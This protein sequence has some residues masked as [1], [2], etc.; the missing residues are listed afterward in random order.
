MSNINFSLRLTH[1]IFRRNFSS[2]QYRYKLLHFLSGSILKTNAVISSLA[3]A[4]RRGGELHNAS[5]TSNNMEAGCKYPL[6]V[7]TE[8]I[9]KQAQNACT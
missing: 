6:F 9:I 4:L 5:V 1:F 3:L 8:S 2:I 7:T